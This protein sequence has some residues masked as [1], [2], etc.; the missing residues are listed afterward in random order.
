MASEG[1]TPRHQRKCRS[2]SGANCNCTPA[3]QARVWSKRDGKRIV[4]TFPTK[5]AAKNW[6][7]DALVKLSHGTLAAPAAI[8]LRD[9]FASW[10]KGAES[11][12]VRDRSGDPY[13]PGTVRT[14]EQN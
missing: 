11:G 9:A 10:V 12:A 7:A 5:A 8:S 6:R 2:R 14:Y 1:L 4:K 13:K 3:W